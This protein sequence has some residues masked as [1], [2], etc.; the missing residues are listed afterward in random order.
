VGQIS[1]ISGTDKIDWTGF[2]MQAA[3]LDR[4]NKLVMV[5]S[6]SGM[7]EFRHLVMPFDEA[8]C[9]YIEEPE[10]MYDMLSAY[11]DWKIKTVELTIEHTK[12]DMI[13]LMM[14]GKQNISVPFT[15]I[16]RKQ[17]SLI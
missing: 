16:W 1:E 5:A 10:A 7:F 3:H 4:E 9:N 12:P 11:T 14:T 13:N 2:D 17:S 8:L 6:F 15:G